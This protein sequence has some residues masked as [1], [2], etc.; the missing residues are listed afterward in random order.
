MNFIFL[1]CIF[2][3]NVNIINIF[4]MESKIGFLFYYKILFVV[5]NYLY[6]SGFKFVI[7]DM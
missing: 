1:K 5:Y 6:V 2:I 3:K 4:N 7:C